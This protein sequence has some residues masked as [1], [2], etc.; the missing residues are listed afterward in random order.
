[1]N[2]LDE[3]TGNSIL[4]KTNDDIDDCYLYIY[5]NKM[6]FCVDI[7]LS[8]YIYDMVEGTQKEKYKLFLPTK[9]NT[10]ISYAEIKK[11][12]ENEIIGTIQKN[13]ALNSDVYVYKNIWTEVLYFKCEGYFFSFDISTNIE[14]I[15]IIY[16]EKVLE[17]ENYFIDNYNNF[18]VVCL[19]INKNNKTK[20]DFK[21]K[22][23]FEPYFDMLKVREFFKCK[24]YDSENKE[25][26]YKSC[27]MMYRF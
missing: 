17:T 1:M 18:K 8:T 5:R 10:T 4:L 7:L 25:N 11:R 16:G 21:E 15:E 20:D 3:V 24:F 13:I 19:I 9:N 6:M 14:K 26:N 22:K 12:D 27:V 2:I 23:R